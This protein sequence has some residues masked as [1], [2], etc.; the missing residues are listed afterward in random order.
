MTKDYSGGAGLLIGHPLDT[1]KARL[2][3]MNTYN[4][5]VDCLVKTVRHETI[6]GLYKGVFIPFMTTGMLH[7]ALFV[8]Y[9]TTLSLLHQGDRHIDKR[10]DLPMKEILFA[11]VVGSIIQLIPSIPI[12]LVKT[13]LQVQKEKMAHFWESSR[14]FHLSHN[15]SVYSSPFDCAKTIYRLG[16]VKALYK[17]G[18]VMLYRD[19]IGFLFYLPVYE[20]LYRNLLQNGYN[21]TFAQVIAGGTAGSAGWFSICPLEVIKNRIQTSHTFPSGSIYKAAMQIYRDEGWI[22]FFK[23][24][25]T[26][27]IR[28]FPVNAVLFVVY[29]KSMMFMQAMSPSRELEA[30][31]NDLLA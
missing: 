15:H 1:V 8:G 7:S 17:G 26:L 23:G 4:G 16:G 20:L 6:A 18:T 25:L 5:I 29:N 9:G 12:E 21:E 24:G 27:I 28:G 30:D 2:Q 19:L 10:K 31:N 13:K 14:T 3:T 11:S 22:A